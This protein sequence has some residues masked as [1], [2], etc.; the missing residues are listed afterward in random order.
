MIVDPVMLLITFT[1]LAY[2]VAILLLAITIRQDRARARAAA[3]EPLEPVMLPRRDD[4]PRH[5]ERPAEAS[6]LV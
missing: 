4:P 1:L 6:A 2:G 3:A 5:S